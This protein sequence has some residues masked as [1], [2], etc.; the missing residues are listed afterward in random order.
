[1]RIPIKVEKFTGLTNGPVSRLSKIPSVDFEGEVAPTTGGVLS[2]HLYQSISAIAETMADPL[3]W[4]RWLSKR[5][6][7]APVSKLL[8]N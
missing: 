6:Y 3:D 8:P 4:V 1:M 7:I 5:S 2:M